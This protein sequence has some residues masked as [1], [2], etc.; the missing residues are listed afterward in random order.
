MQRFFFNYGDGPPD[1]GG[2]ELPSYEEAEAD[3][4]ATLLRSAA[5]DGATQA[6]VTI[7]DEAGQRLAEVSLL[8]TTKRRHG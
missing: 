4:R 7:W 2:V 8:V 1:D 5:D 6:G 3:A